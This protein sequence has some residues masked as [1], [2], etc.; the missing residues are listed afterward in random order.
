MIGSFLLANSTWQNLKS[1]RF[2]ISFWN[3]ENISFVQTAFGVS[4]ITSTT[5][6]RE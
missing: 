6:W 1:S 2:H 5:E 3:F 4:V